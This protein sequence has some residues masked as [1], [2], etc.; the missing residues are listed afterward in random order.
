MLGSLSWK[1]CNRRQL[2][3][4]TVVRCLTRQCLRAGSV[5]SNVKKM[6]VEWH[7]S[8]VVEIQPRKCGWIQFYL[9][10]DIHTRY[11]SVE[12]IDTVV[13]VFCLSLTQNLARALRVAIDFVVIVSKYTVSILVVYMILQYGE[14]TLV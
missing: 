9:I 6:Y 10:C 1:A 7:R 11:N 14:R 12:A 8:D 2:T 5:V 4:P 3:K 13:I